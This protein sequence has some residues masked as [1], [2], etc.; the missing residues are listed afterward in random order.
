MCACG[1]VCAH[2]CMRL[3]MCLCTCVRAPPHV[4]QSYH[5]PHQR[6]H[7]LYLFHFLLIKPCHHMCRV[8][9]NHMFTVCGIFG[10]EITELR[11]QTFRVCLPLAYLPN[12]HTLTHTHIHTHIHTNTYT[13][14]DTHR[15][16]NAHANTYT[17]THT[18]THRHANTHATHTFTHT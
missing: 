1:F 18:D 9:Q 15:H 2:A 11:Y 16:A 6:S 12:T 13:H 8:G 7:R 14:T 5:R 10:M 3:R 17:H 4:L